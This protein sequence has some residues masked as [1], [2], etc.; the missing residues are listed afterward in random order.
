MDP[1][2]ARVQADLSGQLEGEVRCDNTFLQMYASDASI[3]EMIPLGVVRPASVEDVVACV[4]YAEENQ[5]SLVPRGGGSNVAGA[6]V[7]EGLVLDFSYSMRRTQ[8]VG[9]NTVTVQ[10]GLVLGNLNRQLKAHGQIYGPDPATRNVTTIGGTLAM[11]TSGSHWVR[12]GTP[13]ETVMRLQAVIGGGEVVEFDSNENVAGNNAFPQLRAQLLAARVN[14]ILSKNEKLIEEQRP[15][16][17][18]NQAGYNLFDLQQGNQTDLTRLL[19]GSEGTLGIITE[20]TLKTEPLPRHRGVALLF[21]HRLESAAQA[22]VEISKMG[23]SACDLLDRRLLSLARET[24][25]QFHRLIPGD[26]E[27]MLLAEFQAG[28][29]NSLRSKLDHLEQ[30][31]QRRRK[32]AFEVR[33]AIQPEQRD[34]FW[35]IVRRI[36]PTLYRLKGDK[37]ALPFVEDIAVDPPRIPEFLNSVHNI[38]NDNE[39]TA[40][41]FCHAPQGTIHIRP[42]MSLSDP[43][44]IARLQ[45]LA[46]Q[47]FEQVLEFRGTISGRHGDGLSRTWFLRRQYGQ[48]YNVFSD[49]KN[50]FDG[51]CVFNPGKIVG[52]PYSGLGDNLRQV[53]VSDRFLG[54]Q[55]NAE[56]DPNDVISEIESNGSDRTP[57]PGAVA[58]SEDV[59]RR[60]LQKPDTQNISGLP[61]LE[62]TLDWQLPEI[63]KAARNCNGCGR[64]RT[65]SPNERMCPMFRLTPREEASPRAKANLMRGIVTGQLDS[66]LLANDEFKEVAD[67]CVNCHQCRFECPAGVDIP[68]LMVEAKAQYQSANGMRISDWLLTRLD[69]LYEIAGRMP[70]V[71]NRVLQSRSARWLLDRIMGIAQGRKLPLFSKNSFA[72]WS[73]RQ[74]L[75]RS[76]TQQ[77]R[78]IVYFV[79]AYVNWNDVELGQ[80][81]VKVLEHNGINV[82]VPSG[83]NISAMSLISEGLVVR[84]KRLA[85]KNVELLAEWVRQGYKIVTTEPSA[86]L[87][88]SHE[89][90]N[91]LDDPDAN[92]VAEN[93]ID[94]SSFLLQL[95]LSGELELDF[96][97]VNAAIGY[98]LPCHQRALGDEVPAMKLLRLIPGL[99][100]EMI[101]KGCSGMAGTYG[102]KRK[103]YLNSLKMGFGLINTMRSTDIIAGTTECSTCKIQ[104]EQGTTK[105]TIHPIK[106]L[107]M[108]YG[109]MPE[110]EDLFSRRSGDLVVS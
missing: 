70:R 67:L 10:P 65:G 31:I 32:L 43:T 100:V 77:S 53:V 34:L 33:V 110:L 86:A 66:K 99:Q 107:A 55:Q 51:L 96:Q 19:V 40:S 92:I 9:R 42:F 105:P 16:T 30:R 89:Y 91:L 47:L 104:M 95:H 4:K 52:H 36:V 54:P 75:N 26:A 94:A 11:N 7:G 103:N 2:R 93:T 106:I 38:L 14:R 25:V 12:Y 76:S 24:N 46:N 74:K 108:A 58:A 29:D 80:A 90:L 59:K 13:R 71:T 39:V 8:A 17:K 6:C 82:V 72:R 18:Q 78:K 109:L 102:I 3:Y 62:P 60:W 5:I 35:R 21:F 61:I 49:V 48:L 97:P 45:R 68:K 81:F 44:E 83:Q 50:V 15:R 56:P 84:A 101:E 63:A 69:W 57:S 79:D 37:R 73:I 20:A 41:I 27:A 88:L 85:Q 22:A 87:A 1:E 23:I 64:C 98:H 28:D